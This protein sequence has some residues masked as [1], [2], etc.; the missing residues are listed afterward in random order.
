MRGLHLQ[1]PPFEQAKL[2]RCSKGAIFDVAI[3]VR[4]GSPY[5]GKWIGVELSLENGL[6]LFIPEGYLHGFMTLQPSTEV[7][8]KCS[9]F[10]NS[11]SEITIGYDDIELGIKWP[12][13]SNS[14]IISDKDL[15][16]LDFAKFVSPFKFRASK[17]C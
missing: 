17:S 10:Y 16:G 15:S 6:Q 11:K 4:K 1:V 9:N 3:D 5:Y 2:I 8:Y 14:V 7:S 13:G 12:N